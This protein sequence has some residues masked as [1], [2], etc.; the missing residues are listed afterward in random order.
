MWKA[1]YHLQDEA[2]A[3]ETRDRDSEGV[4]VDVCYNSLIL[5]QSKGLYATIA[6]FNRI[7]EY[8]NSSPQGSSFDRVVFIIDDAWC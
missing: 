1:Q 7:I 4:C 5:S 6:D 3:N 2:A 8:H